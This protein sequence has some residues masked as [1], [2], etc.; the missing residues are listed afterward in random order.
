MPSC[1][2]VS[3]NTSASECVRVSAGWVQG[4][5]LKITKQA[6]QQ[7]PNSSGNFEKYLKFIYF[8]SARHANIKNK[9]EKIFRNMKEGT[10]EGK[11]EGEAR[12]DRE[13]RKLIQLPPTWQC[14]RGKNIFFFDFR[15]WN[16]WYLS[17]VKVLQVCPQP[18][19]P[20]FLC[21]WFLWFMRRR[22]HKINTLTDTV[23]WEGEMVGKLR[24]RT[25]RFEVLRAGGRKNDVIIWRNMKATI[26]SAFECQLQ[27]VGYF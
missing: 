16:F 17:M 6:E 25:R 3:V 21:S 22:S 12:R 10:V 8:A 23:G 9:L 20:P 11:G 18:R 15:I 7:Q 27:I 5:L 14:C 24:K 4:A 1:L 2:C 19:P 26:K 13:G